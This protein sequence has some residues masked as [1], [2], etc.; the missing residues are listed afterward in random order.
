MNRIISGL[1][2]KKQGGMSIR[3]MKSKR[4]NRQIKKK[5]RHQYE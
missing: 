4:K 5:S 2:D 1:F 3:K